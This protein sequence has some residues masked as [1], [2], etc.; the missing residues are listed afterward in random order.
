MVDLDIIGIIK[1]TN[2]IDKEGTVSRTT[3]IYYRPEDY[4]SAV[5]YFK[6]RTQF[7]KN[8]RSSDGVDINKEETH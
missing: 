1:A 5:A 4:G 3:N 7:V 6:S 8:T 2:S